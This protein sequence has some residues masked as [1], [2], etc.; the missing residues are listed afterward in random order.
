M[1]EQQI[2]LAPYEAAARIYCAKYG[3]DPDERVPSGEQSSII[4]AGAKLIP[5]WMPVASELLDLS[6]MLTSLREGARQTTQL[7]GATHG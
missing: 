2:E 4:G 7:N 3:I 5:Q 6:I 1:D